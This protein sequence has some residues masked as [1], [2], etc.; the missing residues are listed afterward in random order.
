MFA[1]EFLPALDYSI[2]NKISQRVAHLLCYVDYIFLI[3]ET[4]AVTLVAFD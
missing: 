2:V 1:H 3:S 4:M